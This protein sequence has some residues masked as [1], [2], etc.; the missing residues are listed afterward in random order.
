MKCPNCDFIDKDEAFGDPAT[1]PKCGAIYEK[2]LRIK[3]DKERQELFEKKRLESAQNHHSA[4]LKG[5]LA[6][7]STS[8]SDGREKRATAGAQNQK[9]REQQMVI[10]ADIDMPFWSMVSFMIKWALASV[11]ALFI[12]ALIVVGVVSILRIL[13][14]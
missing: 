4:S 6:H 2:A 5:R 3:A 7:A 8:V 11:P 1:C 14:S 12:L 13:F 9:K 10:V